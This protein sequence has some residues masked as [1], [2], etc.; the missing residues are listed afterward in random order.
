M[1]LLC[2]KSLIDQQTAPVDWT[3]S[4][5]D[6]MLSVRFLLFTFTLLVHFLE[7]QSGHTNSGVPGIGGP[8]TGGNNDLIDEK[9]SPGIAL[10][11]LPD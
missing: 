9:G 3:Q 10:M 1:R 2:P 4:M 11:C 5:I 6:I 7:L 8:G